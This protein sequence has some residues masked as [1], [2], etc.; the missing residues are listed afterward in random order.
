MIDEGLLA[1]LR[2]PRTGKPLKWDDDTKQLINEQDGWVYP[3]RQGMFAL[4]ITD[5]KP[6]SISEEA[7]FSQDHEGLH[8][9]CEDKAS[10]VDG[11]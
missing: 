6:E 11:T 1:I 8:T 5:D 3:R 4:L 2:C 7:G 10:E 9:D